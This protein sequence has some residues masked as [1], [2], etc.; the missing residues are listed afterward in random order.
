MKK[1]INPLSLE[2]RK[3]I[4]LEMLKELDKFCRAK[5]LRYSLAYGTLLG[6]I[7]HKGYIPWDDDVDIIMPLPD[8]EILKKE[9]SSE[10]L[11]YV[12]IETFKYY[13]NTFPRISNR[14]T[15]NR[16][17]KA[18][19]SYGVNID[20]YPVVGAPSN[21]DEINKFLQIGKH[22]RNIFKKYQRFRKSIMR[23]I[24]IREF[25]F[26]S[27][28]LRNLRDYT[29]QYSFNESQVFFHHSGPFEQYQ[30]Y[31]Y[32]VFKELVEVDFEG[33]KF[34]ATARY[35]DYLTKRYGDYMTPPPE[36]Q[37]HPYHG[38]EYY[39]KK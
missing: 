13:D 9:L 17:G 39:W 7:R 6:A 32:D 19:I 21:M 33:E 37:R 3:I 14:E 35:D 11:Q 8:I 20:L 1:E 28:T 27:Q 10:R 38:G 22:K 15:C 26:F 30:I 12:D 18:L 16:Y 23:R 5:G 24:P 31:Y 36:D 4:Q 25:P 2:E 29:Q 34:L